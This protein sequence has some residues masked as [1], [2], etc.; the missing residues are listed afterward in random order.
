MLDINY[1]IRK[2]PKLYAE[3]YIVIIDA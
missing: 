1:L 2:I 3:I